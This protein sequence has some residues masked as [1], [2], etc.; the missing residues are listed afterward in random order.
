MSLHTCICPH[1]FT[2]ARNTATIAGWKKEAYQRMSHDSTASD[3]LMHCSYCTRTCNISHQIQVRT[4]WMYRAPRM[5]EPA[6]TSSTR[7]C[8]CCLQDRKS[9]KFLKSDPKSGWRSALGQGTPVWPT[10]GDSN[11]LTHRNK[12]VSMRRCRCARVTAL[13]PPCCE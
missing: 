12:P 8:P 10:A 3:T 6:M 11:N 4:C 5:P 2:T 13:Q 1:L 9:E 7:S